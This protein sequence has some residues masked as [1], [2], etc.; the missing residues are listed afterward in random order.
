[1]IRR[2]T[3]HH[4]EEVSLIESVAEELRE[5][6]AGLIE[7]G[8]SEFQAAFGVSQYAPSYWRLFRNNALPALRIALDFFL[9]NESVSALTL[10]LFLGK[11]WRCL[12]TLGVAQLT[13]DD[14]VAM[15][16]YSLLYC[17]GHLFLVDAPNKDPEVY[18]GDDSLALMWHLVPMEGAKVLDVCSGS[19]IQALQSLSYAREVHAV[20][21]NPRA[22][23]I[24][25]IN[26]YINGV[27]AKIKVYGGS[28]FESVP[29]GETYDLIQANPPLVPFPNDVSYPFVGHGGTDGLAITRRILEELPVRLSPKGLGQIIGLSFSDGMELIAH[30]EFARVARENELDIVLTV[31]NHLPLFEESNSRFEAL[32]LTAAAAA[33]EEV[34][35]VR[36]KFRNELFAQGAT[37]MAPFFVLAKRGTGH[38]T[39]QNLSRPRHDGFWAV[40]GI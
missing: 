24:L 19:G 40:F 35:V 16:K 28:L 29:S 32:V 15:S 7:L 9:L 5:L 22:R 8:Y 30:E 20:E 33:H 27:G 12:L 11:A 4:V 26:S 6:K 38:L 3:S 21:I 25:V 14:D 1:M 10:D 23:S 2:S 17:L 34:S 13:A 37:H 31:I 36:L 18:F 39:V